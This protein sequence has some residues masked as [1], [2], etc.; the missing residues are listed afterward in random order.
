[1]WEGKKIW[2]IHPLGQIWW[3]PNFFLNQDSL[4]FCDNKTDASIP[5]LQKQKGNCFYWWNGPDLGLNL[6][7]HLIQY[8]LSRNRLS[9]LFLHKSSLLKEFWCI[10]ILDIFKAP[11]HVSTC[12]WSAMVLR[13]TRPADWHE[14]PACST[15]YLG[16]LWM[17][18]LPVIVI[19]I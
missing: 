6:L 13:H 2:M 15:L 12:N 8:F 1:M 10:T 18:C 17:K 14:V 11:Q 5:L 7:E 4:V 3:T 19:R 16:I 9:L